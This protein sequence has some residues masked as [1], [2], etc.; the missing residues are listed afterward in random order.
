MAPN[1]NQAHYVRKLT[2][3]IQAVG[4][5]PAAEG[6]VTVITKTKSLNKPVKSQFTSV[7]GANKSARK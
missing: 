2:L 6:G 3:E 5:A 1:R 7:Q 4:I